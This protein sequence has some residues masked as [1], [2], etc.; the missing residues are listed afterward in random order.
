MG[1]ATRLTAAWETLTGKTAPQQR[2]DNLPFYF[3]SYGTN[4]PMPNVRINAVQLR[5]FSKIPAVRRAVT[6]VTNAIA[7]LDWDIVPEDGRKLTAAQKRKVAQLKNVFKRPNAEDGW[8]AFVTQLIVD[9]LVIG[10]FACEVRSWDGNPDRPFLLFPIDAASLQLYAEWD[11]SDGTS[12]YAQWSP[13]GTAVN[14]KNTEMFFMRYLPTTDTP[15]SASPTEVA[16]NHVQYLLDAESYASRTA[17]NATP[18]RG[19]FLGG[20]LQESQVRE[21]REYFKNEIMGRGNMP[22]IGGV[23]DA[24]GIDLG[25]SGDEALYLGWQDKLVSIIAMAF[26]LDHTKFNLSGAAG[27]TRS[28]GEMLNDVS[29]DSAIRPM[30]LHLQDSITTYFCHYF[31]LGGIAQFKFIFNATFT[32]R[33]ALAVISQINLQA[34]RVT[35]DESRA[36]EGL[37]P[38]PDGMG[39]MTLSVYRAKYAAAVVSGTGPNGSNAPADGKPDPNGNGGNNGVNGA[40]NPGEAASN[41]N[42]DHALAMTL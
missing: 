34:D 4:I 9:L 21:F 30:A 20:D 42:A 38:L 10:H 5:Q 6:Y 15:W 16:A 22:I 23:T 36:D 11:G 13:H 1:I 8:N 28:S 27:V 7:A 40:T 29:T 24:K 25:V 39:A 3:G 41:S 18:K 26:S 19:L 35:I 33:K 14:F 37:P 17:S 31:G 32:D 12:R 2:S